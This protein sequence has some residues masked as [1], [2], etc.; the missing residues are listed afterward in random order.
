MALIV[1]SFTSL[2]RE[3]RGRWVQPAGGHRCLSHVPVAGGLR[4]P[5][6]WDSASR[7]DRGAQAG[8]STP[9]RIAEDGEHKARHRWGVQDNKPVVPHLSTDLRQD[10]QEPKV[11]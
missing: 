2:G 10:P 6:G 3:Q 9:C 7:K 1:G 11:K 5:G 4:E 8:G